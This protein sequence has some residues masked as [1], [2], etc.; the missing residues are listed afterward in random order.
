[1][2]IFFAKVLS[3]LLFPP[4]ANLILLAVAWPFRRR[5]PRLVISI[6]LFSLGSLYVFSTPMGAYG[7]IQSLQRSPA[8]VSGALE[9]PV[10]AIV[11][12][13][14]GRYRNAPEYGEDTVSKWTLERLRYG[15]RL[16]RQSGLPLLVTGG[17]V[18]EQ[19]LPE[20]ELMARVLVEDFRVPVRWRET[21][22]RNT[23][24]NAVFTAP[25]LAAAGI[26]RVLLVTHASHMPRSLDAF[27]RNGI[28]AIAAP[29]GFFSRP[30]PG[31][32]VLNW[33]PRASALHASTRALHEYLGLL[34]YRLRY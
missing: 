15:A 7:L 9:E 11:I 2:G 23:W 24:E 27:R 14:G 17:N 30:S 6:V 12:L 10:G 26:S 29:T 18:Y 32:G 16:H 33:L 13:G 34:W 8:L 22:S 1:M 28:M 25:L 19:R 31:R 4:A 3:T 20:A 5:W 21:A